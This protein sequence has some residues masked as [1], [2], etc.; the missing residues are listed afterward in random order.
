MS[1]VTLRCSSWFRAFQVTPGSPVEGTL[2]AGD[3]ILAISGYDTSQ[4]THQQASDMIRH[5]GTTLQM[6]IE[7]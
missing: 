2:S 5:A 4:M 3:A 6:Q 1:P 7:K